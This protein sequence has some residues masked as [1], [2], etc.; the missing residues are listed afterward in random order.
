[1]V[2]RFTMPERRAPCYPLK[3]L[4]VK[5]IIRHVDLHKNLFNLKL[6]NNILCGRYTQVELMS[7][8]GIFPKKKSKKK[9]RLSQVFP[10]TIFFIED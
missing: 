7:K 4:I 10:S 8:A 5:W 3:G 1:M 6:N 2:I 9:T